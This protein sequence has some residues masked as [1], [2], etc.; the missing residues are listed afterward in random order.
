MRVII[1]TM[2]KSRLLAALTSA[3]KQ[4]I[5]GATCLSQN[6]SG[7]WSSCASRGCPPFECPI[8]PEFAQILLKALAIA[9]LLREVP[10]S[11]RLKGRRT[12]DENC[13]IS[14]IS[15]E[16]EKIHKWRS[17]R[18]ICVLRPLTTPCS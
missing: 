5:L 11:G 6:A 8:P 13:M 15:V 16:R 2:R 4:H 9:E 1:R 17:Y 12:S 14:L 3:T 7:I 10:Q 18:P